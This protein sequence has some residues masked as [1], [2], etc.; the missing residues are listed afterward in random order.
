[1]IAPGWLRA[2]VGAAG[3]AAAAWPLH[4]TF[5]GGLAWVI[6]CAVAC[7]GHG[8]ALARLT[9][10]R[11]SPPLAATAGL[12]AMLVV[13]TLLGALGLLAGLVQRGLVLAGIA[14]AAL[15]RGPWDPA[16]AGGAARFRR[17]LGALAALLVI[18]LALVSL[19]TPASDDANH[20]LAVKR[21]WDTGALAGAPYT[22]GLHVAGEALLAWGHGAAAAGVF[23]AFCA[24]LLVLVIAAELPAEDTLAA[25]LAHWIAA[26]V[27]V[28]APPT[29]GQLSATLFHLAAILSLRA[30]LEERRTGWHT[31]GFAAALALLRHELLFLAVPYA[32]AAVLLPRASR[33][34]RRQISLALAAWLV[35]AFGLG[36]ALGLPP[37]N[38]LGKAFA[39]LAAVPL[40]ALLLRLLGALPW[41]GR[42]GA[43]CFALVSYLLA[44]AAYAIP[45]ARHAATATAAVTGA[46]ALLVLVTS[47]AAASAAAAASDAARGLAAAPRLAAA[48]RLAAAP[49]LAEGRIHP[50]AAS[51]VIGIFASTSL[52]LPA[53]EEDHV[54]P[55]FA[56]ALLAWR[57][58]LV[59]D[60]DRAHAFVHAAQL[61]APAGARLAFWGLS[62]ARLDFARNPIR[63][64]SFSG[65]VLL[66]PLAPHALDGADYLLLEDLRP[67]PRY[68]RETKITTFPLAL[69]AAADRLEFVATEGTA[70]LFRVRD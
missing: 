41:R 61:R 22:S 65:R 4:A 64:V 9:G 16:P 15:P 69:E 59:L 8:G 53:F 48:S 42:H 47:V 38:A 70:H 66:A 28:L 17:L 18:V 50:A 63:D 5:A 2:A 25:R 26:A 29:H 24:A 58:R 33:P 35:V 40:A 37:G 54:A 11:L 52:L 55:R 39:L 44:V 36:L 32:A 3:A 34:S 68:D 60:P 10:A 62:A 20:V 56:A 1:M 21:L 49:R 57:E 31:L 6:A 14:L 23:E 67:P 27:I 43:V 30:P 51:L 45:P 13:A 7:S 19:E 46:V 12:A